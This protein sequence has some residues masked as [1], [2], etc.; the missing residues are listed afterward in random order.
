MKTIITFLK[1]LFT[2]G[3]KQNPALEL[4]N[5]KIDDLLLAI[6]NKNENYFLNDSD[7]SN[8]LELA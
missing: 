3:K 7:F 6:D 2:I 8:E 5:I 4:S 1:N